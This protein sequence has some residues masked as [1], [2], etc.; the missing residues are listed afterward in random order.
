MDV[1]S[2]KNVT[3]SENRA[4][5][6]LRRKYRKNRHVFYPRCQRLAEPFRIS[7]NDMRGWVVLDGKQG[8]DWPR[9]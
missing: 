1:K 9:D 8:F 3:R 2:F 7:K 4:R 5:L 6:Y